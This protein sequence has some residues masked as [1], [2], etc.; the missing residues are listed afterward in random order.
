MMT[1]ETSSL[2]TSRDEPQTEAFQYRIRLIR[3][4]RDS[5]RNLDSEDLESLLAA[6]AILSWQ[7]PTEYVYHGLSRKRPF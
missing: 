6:S 5:I 1:Y 2:I 7:S 3:H 4:M